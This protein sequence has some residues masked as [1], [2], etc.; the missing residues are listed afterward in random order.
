MGQVL[1]EGQQG[2]YVDAPVEGAQMVEGTDG[3]L[4]AAEPVYQQPVMYAAPPPIA[5]PARINVSPEIFAK[6]AAGGTLTPEEMAQLSGE[7]VP[8]PVE[9]AAAAVAPVAGAASPAAAASTA[10]TSA[11]ASKK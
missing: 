1:M 8:A 5:A 6:L 3:M 4:M 11:K 2:V 10:V 9:A 7:P